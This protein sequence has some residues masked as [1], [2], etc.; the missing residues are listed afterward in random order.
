LVA[1]ALQRALEEGPVGGGTGLPPTAKGPAKIEEERAERATVEM[2]DDDE[3]SEAVK[4]LYAD[5][6]ATLGLPLV[7]SDYRAMALW[8]GGFDLLITPTMQQPPPRIGAVAPDQLGAVFGLFTMPFSITGQPAV[9]LPL[10]WSPEGLP[11]GVQLVADYG[12]EDL[13]IRV[14]SQLEAARP[15]AARRPPLYA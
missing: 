8:H 1:T 5:I 11:I 15:W 4:M 2:V 13:L 10:H 7:N 3:S 6:K 14:A 9:S 12:R